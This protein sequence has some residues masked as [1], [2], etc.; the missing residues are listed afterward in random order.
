MPQFTPK[1]PRQIAADGLLPKGDYDFTVRKADPAISKAG[2]EMLKLTLTIFCGE[3]T[4]TIFDYLVFSDGGMS[5]L[6]GF[7]Q[8]TGLEEKYHKG[9]I[10]AH[11][12][13][14]RSG[15]CYVKTDDKDADFE[16]KNAIARYCKPKSSP[17]TPEAAPLHD[18]DVPF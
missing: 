1:D 6:F 2:N 13:E 12:C 4:T 18:E 7:C 17:T 5:K 9:E 3:R 10:S 15:K 8:A 11:D 14:G 16:P